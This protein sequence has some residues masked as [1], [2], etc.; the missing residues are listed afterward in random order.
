MAMKM[1]HSFPKSFGFHGSA[2]GTYVKSHTRGTPGLYDERTD[3]GHKHM[4]HEIVTP[5][6][7]AGHPENRHVHGYHLGHKVLMKADGGRV[8]VK[9]KYSKG[10]EVH[11]TKPDLAEDNKTK[12][13]FDKADPKEF[14]SKEESWTDFSEGGRCTVRD[15]YARGGSVDRREYGETHEEA[16]DDRK[17]P[18]ERG[19]SAEDERVSD[20]DEHA[21][22]SPK[23]RGG[24]VH[25]STPDRYAFGG[26]SRSPGANKAIHAKTHKPTAGMRGMGA[27][28]MAAGPSMA[29][30]GAGGGAPPGMPPPPPL[31]GVGPPGM[32][33]G[34]KHGGRS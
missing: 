13:H 29:P 14:T 33:G 25:A 12:K 1:G 2:G 21:T 30:L 27:L 16:A 22:T 26:M 3:G 28:G 23:A 20:E 18:G 11:R 15:K 8:T 31:G 34:M 19:E 32:P 6:H 9:Y 5:K 7:R 17:Q 24:S 10:G 4:H